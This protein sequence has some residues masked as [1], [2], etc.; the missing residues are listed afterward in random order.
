M[1]WL[2]LYARSRQVPASLAATLLAATVLWAFA[3][4]GG[5]GPGDPR[6]AAFL[7]T[8]G[9]MAFSVGLSGQDPALDRTAATPWPYRRA[10]HVVL[11]ATTVGATLLL[12]QTAGDPMATTALVVRDC[13]GLTGLAA[14]GA[15]LSGGQYAWTL[16]FGWLALAYFAPLGQSTLGRVA[17]WPVQPPGTE[18]A[19]WTALALAGAGTVAYAVAGPRQ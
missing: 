6:P 11:A 18:A 15:A 10:A 2:T 5:G 14:L 12:L 19:T 3:G 13:A 1:R 9:V 17:T 4:D 7:L 16:P 8:T